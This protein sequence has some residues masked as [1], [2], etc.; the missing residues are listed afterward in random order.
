MP[1]AF[2]KGYTGWLGPGGSSPGPAATSGYHAQVGGADGTLPWRLLHPQ[3]PM[4]TDG[5]AISIWHTACALHHRVHM[6]Q[7]MGN[8]GMADSGP[9]PRPAPW[10]APA[11]PARHRAPRLGPDAGQPSG[12]HALRRD[13]LEAN[14]DAKSARD[15][16][17][18]L[19]SWQ[20]M[21][22]SRLAIAARQIGARPS[23]RCGCGDGLGLVPVLEHGMRDLLHVEG[24]VPILLVVIRELRDLRIDV[25]LVLGVRAPHHH[26]PV[27]ELGLVA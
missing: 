1:P 2:R 6:V 25:H 24:L 27:A 3:H 8:E 22:D 18:A 19:P 14:L 16:S 5:M 9:S 26:E 23:P 20:L 17:R 4:G 12:A 15:E 10:N 21:E 11:C 13:G 7:T